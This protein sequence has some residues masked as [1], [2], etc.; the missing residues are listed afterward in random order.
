MVILRQ[1]RTAPSL[2]LDMG[3]RW[4][5]SSFLLEP[6]RSPPVL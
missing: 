1:A 5:A 2:S 3:L 4:E 6:S